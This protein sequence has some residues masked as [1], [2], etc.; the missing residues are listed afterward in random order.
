MLLKEFMPCE[1]VSLHTGFF[2]RCQAP[3]NLCQLILI[4]LL[5]LIIIIING[6]G[7]GHGHPPSP[8]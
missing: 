2:P 3:E 4:L 6:H 5:L 7:H 8:Q 1:C